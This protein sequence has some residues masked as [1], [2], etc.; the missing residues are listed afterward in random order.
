M[1]NWIWKKKPIYLYF[2]WLLS[3]RRLCKDNILPDPNISSEKEE[4]SHLDIQRKC[5]SGSQN[6]QIMCESHHTKFTRSL[7]EITNEIKKIIL[8]AYME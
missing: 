2:N 3:W 6:R 4:F 7:I 8:Y 5:Q 1:E